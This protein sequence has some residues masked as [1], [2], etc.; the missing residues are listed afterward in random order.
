MLPV[1]DNVNLS[2]RRRNSGLDKIDEDGVV[3]CFHAV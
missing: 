2:D 1:K 3:S